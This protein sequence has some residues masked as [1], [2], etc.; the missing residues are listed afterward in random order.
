[1]WSFARLLCPPFRGLA[2]ASL[3]SRGFG[4]GDVV[5]AVLFN[6]DGESGT[7]MVQ[8]SGE[9]GISGFPCGV[10]FASGFDYVARVAVAPDDGPSILCHCSLP[11]DGRIRR[12]EA[13]LRVGHVGKYLTCHTG[14]SVISSE[15]K[16]ELRGS[17]MYRAALP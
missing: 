2:L 4:W 7:T 12:G 14:P 9:R 13:S 8:Q 6:G 3:R 10:G 17:A 15:K 1:M 16:L 5:G 11:G